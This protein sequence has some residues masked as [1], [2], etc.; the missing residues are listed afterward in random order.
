[1]I[2]MSIKHILIAIM[3]ISTIYDVNY[4]I[5]RSGDESIVL[6]I[7]ANSSNSNNYD[8]TIVN[9]INALTADSSQDVA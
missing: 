3:V 7:E 4:T 8:I 2:L 1:M 5:A 9:T 6:T